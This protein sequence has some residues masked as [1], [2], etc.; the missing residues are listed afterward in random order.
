MKRLFSV[1]LFLVVLVVA[2]GGYA[3]A[4]GKFAKVLPQEDSRVLGASQQDVKSMF[5]SIGPAVDGAYN[6]VS[7]QVSSLSD[8]YLKEDQKIEVDK[9][10]N[11]IKNNAADI[12]ENVFNDA[13]YNYCKSVVTDYEKTH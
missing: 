5:S 13:K 7:N 4:K 3:F 11:D 6:S 12:P 10:F 9:A 1:V 2:I 8:K